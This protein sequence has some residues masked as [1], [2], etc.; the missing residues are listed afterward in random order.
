MDITQEAPGQLEDLSL[1][2]RMNR[3]F[4]SQCNAMDSKTSREIMTIEQMIDLNKA[5]RF[6]LNPIYQRE[7]VW[8]EAMAS[9]LIESVMANLTIPEIYIRRL[10]DGIKT[11]D[12][13]VDGK[14]RCAT[15]LNFYFNRRELSCGIL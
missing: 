1:E 5:N 13:I 11:Y 10:V 8:Q 2:D 9:R 6:D 7:Y 4:L 15:L 14:Q 12:E 3:S